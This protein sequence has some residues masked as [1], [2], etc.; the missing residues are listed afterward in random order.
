MTT[1]LYT[2][3]EV[4]ALT[5]LPTETLTQRRDRAAVAFLFLSGARNGAF[6]SLP[7]KA[8]DLK[9]RAISQLPELGV[10]TKFRKSAITYLLDIP[11][12]LEI[13]KRWDNL[14]RDRLSL[15]ALWYATLSRDGME[16]TG[17]TEPG[18]GR[19]SAVRRG[20]KE[21][22]RRAGISYR[23]PHHLRHG[24]AVYAF[25]LA[26]DIVDRQAIKPNLMHGKRDT[27]D[28]YTWLP[29]NEVARRIASLTASDQSAGDAEALARAFVE[30][31]AENPSALDWI[32]KGLYERYEKIGGTSQ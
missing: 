3:E 32:A 25:N 23:A 22:C 27:T 15:D 2:L 19:A 9:N 10:M 30:S 4:L 11:D 6:V 20:L 12:L 28:I 7:I 31:L 13:V 16:F 17:A 21:L 18:K 29:D 24:H 1:G 26:G 5:A 8:V 14:V